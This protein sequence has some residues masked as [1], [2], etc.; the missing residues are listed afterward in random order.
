MYLRVKSLEDPTFQHKVNTSIGIINWA[1]IVTIV[2]IA[3]VFYRYVIQQELDT[4]NLDISV[5]LSFTFI[6]SILIPLFYTLNKA[7]CTNFYANEG[8]KQKLANL[9]IN[10]ELM[11]KQSTTTDLVRSEHQAFLDNLDS[12]I[13]LN[14]LYEIP[15]YK[16]L[17]AIELT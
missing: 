9:R 16:F 7:V 17:G 5:Y 4:N 3:S 6:L 1:L 10:I 8:C 14:K 12:I 13:S 11:M 15:K 2:F